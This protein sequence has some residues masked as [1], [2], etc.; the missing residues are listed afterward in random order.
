M[1]DIQVLCKNRKAKT[2]LSELF[3]VLQC[4]MNE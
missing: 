1:P 4:R 2:L 3:Y